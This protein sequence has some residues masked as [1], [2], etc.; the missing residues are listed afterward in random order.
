MNS[1]IPSFN[2]FYANDLQKNNNTLYHHHKLELITPN[3]S[4]CPETQPLSTAD[5]I[6]NLIADIL[7]F[8][9]SILAMAAGAAITLQSLGLSSPAIPMLSGLLMPA[10]T[11]VLTGSHLSKNDL[12][13]GT[14][15]K[16]QTSL[17]GLS[18]NA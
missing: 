4:R 11:A 13:N 5:R 2:Y 1:I 8:F 16:L 12:R 7:I 18:F 9:G 15:L 3:Q 14:S 6:K 17:P 10:V